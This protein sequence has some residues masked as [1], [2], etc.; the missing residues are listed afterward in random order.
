M[1]TITP[2]T[3][4]EAIRYFADPKICLDFV[5]S[6]RWPDG[7]PTCPE[8][9]G[10]EV[11]FISTRSLWKCKGCKKQ[12]SVKVGTIF[13]DSALSLDKWLAA[14]WLIA[15]AKNGISSYE[16]GRSLGITQKSAW[17]MLHR[18]RL[19][20]QTGTFERQLDG[21]VE[22]DETFIGGKAKFMHK[23]KRAERILGRGTVGKTV[24]QGVLE[25]GGEVR[26]SVVPN[27]K[28]GTLQE[29]VKKH[30]APGASVFTDTLRSYDGLDKQYAHATVDHSAG[31]YVDGKV[32]T[33]GM[34]NFWSLVKRCLKGTYIAVAAWHLYRYLDEEAFRFNERLGNDAERFVTVMK[35]IAG[36]RLTYRECAGELGSAEA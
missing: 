21:E 9:S 27:Q 30:V 1:E 26:V 11:S 25:R 31:Q 10:Q 8:C 5:A 29:T 12:F 23:S 20:M 36:K 33:N 15:N 35:Q 3:L 6:L 19:A 24:V 14:V 28:K 13:E 2:Q 18:I 4:M 16:I 34:E 7:K 17:H 32:H 22:A